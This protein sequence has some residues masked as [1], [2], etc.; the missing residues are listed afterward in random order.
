MAGICTNS[1]RKNGAGCDH[2]TVTVSFD[3][4]SISFDTMQAELAAMDWSAGQLPATWLTLPPK[5]LF[6]RLGVL[7]LHLV[8]GVAL[9][10]AIGRVVNG[11]EG[12]NV[13]IYDFFGPGAAITKTNIGTSYVNICPGANGEPLVAD[14]TG[15]T[16]YRIRLYANLVG[17]GQ[18][19]AQIKKTS[20]GDVLHEAPNLG[21]AGERAVDTNWQALPAAFQGQGLLELVAQ[22]KSQTGADDPVFRAISLGLR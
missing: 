2:R 11:E 3:G 15:C 13:K 5:K 12:T 1:I 10:D 22:A 21:A 20:N 16:E 4:E 17:T 6:I 14:F 7:W 18:W 9:D 8:K 19:G